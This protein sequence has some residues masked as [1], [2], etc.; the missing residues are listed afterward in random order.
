MADEILNAD[1]SPNEENLKKLRKKADQVDA[2][3]AEN[4]RL[5]R[6]LALRDSKVN[7]EHPTFELFRDAYKG[8]WTSEALDEAAKKYG[9][10]VEEQKPE[11]KPEQQSQQQEQVQNP[12]FTPLQ[13][14]YLEQLGLNQG[15]MQTAGNA[16]QQAASAQRAIDSAQ[17]S[18][19]LSVP[20]QLTSNDWMQANT[21][22]EALAR[23][24]A[25][26]GVTSAE[27]M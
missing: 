14:Q 3:S 21:P 19:Q 2:L 13:M 18:G 11:S 5:T 12:G 26:G 17:R 4:Q 27:Q 15:G 8:D 22:E 25:A 6:E 10:L 16:L 24:Q 7:R 1:G 23:Y 20:G 9:L